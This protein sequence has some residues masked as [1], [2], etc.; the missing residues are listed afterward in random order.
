[1]QPPP[2]PPDWNMQP[3]PP[4]PDL[5]MEILPPPPPPT[6]HSG[7][8]LVSAVKKFLSS[9]ILT[10][11][12]LVALKNPQNLLTAQKGLNKKNLQ[13]SYAYLRIYSF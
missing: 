6:H 5:D 9:S 1:M 8:H 7:E 10:L 3:P 13:K 4:P 12:G 11:N 2:P